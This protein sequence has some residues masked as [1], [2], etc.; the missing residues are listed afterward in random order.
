MRTIDR[1]GLRTKMQVAPGRTLLVDVRDRNDYEKE[2]I[3][4]AISIPIGELSMRSKECFGQ[5]HEIIVYCGSFDCPASVKAANMLE[6]MGFSKVVDYEGGLDDWKI[7]GFLTE[8]AQVVKKAPKHA[9]KAAKP[10][11][12]AA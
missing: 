8:G 9:D 3:K 10:A 5:D 6:K 2:H 1:D 11:K 12:K 4:G 7:A